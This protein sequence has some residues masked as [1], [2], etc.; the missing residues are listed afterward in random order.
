[1]IYFV[2]VSVSHVLC[3]LTEVYPYMWLKS[4]VGLTFMKNRPYRYLVL[5]NQNLPQVEPT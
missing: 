1:M 3:T 5:Q 2:F 4:E